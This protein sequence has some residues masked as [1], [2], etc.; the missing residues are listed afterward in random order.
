ML[1]TSNGEPYD[2][3]LGLKSW[4][5]VVWAL[6]LLYQFWFL[7]GCQ[8]A[9]RIHGI[10]HIVGMEICDINIAVDSPFLWL[11]LFLPVIQSLLKVLFRD[12]G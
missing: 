6:F 3:L 4:V 11:L 10:L 2:A 12:F 7:Q 5:G 9:R 1:Y 8:V